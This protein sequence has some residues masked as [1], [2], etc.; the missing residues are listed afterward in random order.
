[1]TANSAGGERASPVV[2]VAYVLLNARSDAG[3]VRR[4]ADAVMLRLRV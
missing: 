4:F 3:N 2:G 1:L